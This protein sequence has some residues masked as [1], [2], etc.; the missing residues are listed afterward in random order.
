MVKIKR[1]HIILTLLFIL[2]LGTRLF[3]VL[4]EE[5]FDYNAYHALR[6]AEHIKQTGLPLFQDQLSYSGR[7]FITPPFFYYLLAVFSLILPLALIA[8]LI[9]SIA[10]SALIIVIYLIAKHMTKNKTAAFI[11]AFFSGFVLIIYTTLNQVSVYSLSLLLIFLLSYTFLRIEQKGFAL[12]S[13]IL[14]VLLLLTHP[15]VFIL[16][17]ASWSTFLYKG[18]ENKSL[19]QKK[20]K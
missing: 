17:L 2:V 18:L 19:T 14:T 8:K 20:L 15:S 11:A 10:F 13:I 6:Q 1:E 16:L 9:P 3:F 5:R 4:Q 12:L 7:T